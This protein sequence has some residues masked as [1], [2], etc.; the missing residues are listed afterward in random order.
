MA[1]QS[2]KNAVK[3]KNLTSDEM[4]EIGLAL[5]KLVGRQYQANSEK[6]EIER[7]GFHAYSCPYCKN[8]K[9]TNM[10]PKDG[11]YESDR[12]QSKA[13]VKDKNALHFVVSESNEGALMLHFKYPFSD[14]KFDVDNIQVRD[15]YAESVGDSDIYR[16]RAKSDYYPLSKDD[17]RYVWVESLS[18][19]MKMYNEKGLEETLDVLG[20]RCTALE[21]ENARLYKMKKT[22]SELIADVENA[23]KLEQYKVSDDL[24]GGD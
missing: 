18:E 3:D 19:A 8:G 9:L 4:L 2:G 13:G 22:K 6:E 5:N 20:K 14:G 12:W 1:K 10:E 7:S 17:K 23:E 11:E 16:D 24:Q 21:Q 15:W